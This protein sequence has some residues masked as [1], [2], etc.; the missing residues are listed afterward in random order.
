MAVGVY[1]LSYFKELGLVFQ[2]HPSKFNIN[3]CIFVCIFMYIHTHIYIC[4]NYL[5]I[6]LYILLDMCSYVTNYLE[7]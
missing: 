1:I 3:M 2:Q 4:N 6:Y 7:T 5:L